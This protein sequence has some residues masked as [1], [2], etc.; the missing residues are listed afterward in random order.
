MSTDGFFANG[1]SI[2]KYTN[3]SHKAGGYFLS[4]CPDGFNIHCICNSK[5]FHISWEQ[6]AFIVSDEAQAFMTTAYA[7]HW[8][9]WAMTFR[10]FAF[11]GSV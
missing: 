1:C 9:T 6:L 8:G 4:H 10:F 3:I 11:C 5:L 7:A 2:S